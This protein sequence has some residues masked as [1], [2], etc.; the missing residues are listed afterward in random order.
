MLQIDKN[1]YPQHFAEHG[2]VFYVMSKLET[3][4]LQSV[5]VRQVLED[6]KLTIEAKINQ[7]EG[8]VAGGAGK[9]WKV[10]NVQFVLKSDFFGKRVAKFI[11]WTCWLG[12]LLP[13]YVL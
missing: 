3:L 1:Q 2:H 8:R 12:Y 5:T 6:T 11:N 13:L 9:L 4:E 7:I 10:C